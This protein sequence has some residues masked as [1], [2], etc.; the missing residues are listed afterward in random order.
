[1]GLFDTVQRK[2]PILQSSKM[3]DKIGKMRKKVAWNAANLVR[4]PLESIK[5]KSNSLQMR[6]RRWKWKVTQAE[7]GGTVQGQNDFSAKVD[8]YNQ[9]AFN[10]YVP[11]PFEGDVHLFR[12]AKRQF[13]VEDFE[14]LGW[15]PFV[16]GRLHIHDVPG[17]HLHLFNPPHGKKLAEILQKIL[18]QLND[19]K[20]T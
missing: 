9:E 1:M 4:H 14:T 18:I 15:A 3:G 6:M 8:R 13:Y 10:K 11:R 19:S 16:H 5:Y 2:K 17:D 20:N 12:A 7:Q